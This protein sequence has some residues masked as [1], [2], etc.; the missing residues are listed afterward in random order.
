MKT[1]LLV[2]VGL[3]GGA[4]VGAGMFAFF[5]A[6]GVIERVIDI[7]RTEAYRGMYKIAILL[8]SLLSTLIYM[9]RCGVRANRGWL[10]LIGLP[11]GIFVG[12]IASALTEVLNVIPFLSIRIGI[13]KW[14]YLL[15]I[16][17][18]LGKVLGSILYWGLLKIQ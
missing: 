13:I 4:L 11:M 6:L 7:S 9:F 14:A 2:I 15:I 16:A 8:G 1:F 5:I 17:I 12:M 18:I 3:S 10:L